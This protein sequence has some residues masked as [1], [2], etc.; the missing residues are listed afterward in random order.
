M[1]LFLM[2]ATQSAGILGITNFVILI[3]ESLGL[4][5]SM[6]LLMYAVYT[7]VATIPNFISSAVMDRIGRRTLLRTLLFSTYPLRYSFAADNLPHLVIG[8]PSIAL[9]LLAEALLQRRYVGTEDRAGNG[10]ALF[11]IFLYG[12]FYGF[13][14]DPPQFV[15]CTEIFPTTIR[16]KGAGLTF[17]SYFVGA[18]TYTTPGALAFKN[19]G[20]RMYMVWFS[21]NVVSTVIIYFFL[22]ETARLPLE[23]VGALFGD[24][25]VVHMTADGQG[26]AEVDNLETA[27]PFQNGTSD[28][29]KSD[30]EHREDQ[31]KHSDSTN[32]N[33][34]QV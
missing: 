9:I 2:F 7:I 13:F 26:L 34:Q 20:W 23:E 5:G 18:I 1:V 17:F 6:P 3:T 4:T 16:A 30:P 24:E 15:W 10:A 27:L 11:F 8:F 29:G 12:A 22:P 19:I 25:V 31:E 32:L 28:S 14:L 33:P 21:C